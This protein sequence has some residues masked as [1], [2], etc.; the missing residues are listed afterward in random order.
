MSKKKKK[1]EDRYGT[2]M[3]VEMDADA[4]VL[5]DDVK[6]SNRSLEYSS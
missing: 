6:R 1:N 2:N 4:R 3:E 5:I